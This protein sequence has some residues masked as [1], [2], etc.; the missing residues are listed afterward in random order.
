MAAIAPR[1]AHIALAEKLGLGNGRL[2]NIDLVR[3]ELG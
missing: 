2:E 3:I 1:V